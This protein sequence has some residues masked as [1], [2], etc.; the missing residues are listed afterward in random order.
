MSDTFEQNMEYPQGFDEKPGRFTSIYRGTVMENDDADQPG[1]RLLRIQVHV[2]QVFGEQIN[3]EDLPWAWPA[4][5]N[6]GGSRLGG[7]PYGIVS[8]P[9]IGSEVWVMFENGNPAR[10]VYLGSVYGTKDASPETPDDFAKHSAFPN[11]FLIRLPGTSQG[12]NN[13]L[14]RMIDK[15]NIELLFDGDNY[16]AID[17]ETQ[18]GRPAPAININVKDWDINIKVTEEGDINLYTK[19]GDISVKSDE[20]NIDL[21][22]DDINI[23]ARGRLNMSSVEPMSIYSQAKIEVSG[24]LY[25]GISA[26]GN[27]NQNGIIYGGGTV[28]GSFAHPVG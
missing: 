8:L 10:P 5:A 13:M 4:A 2:K 18:L 25:T 23:T 22:A 24:Y 20:G 7:F 16:I 3:V 21:E 11:L 15:S 27:E 9:P 17:K 12:P 19:K 1:G 28:A 26:R 6:Y 14:F